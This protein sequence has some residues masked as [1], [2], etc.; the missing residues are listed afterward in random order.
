MATAFTHCLF[1][2][3]VKEGV[4]LSGTPVV[5]SPEAAL[6]CGDQW[7]AV[8]ACHSLFAE[9]AGQIPGF[10]QCFPLQPGCMHGIDRKLESILGNFRNRSRCLFGEIPPC[11]AVVALN[12]FIFIPMGN[13]DANKSGWQRCRVGSAYGIRCGASRVLPHTGEFGVR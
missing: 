2:L 6:L 3:L 9:Q 1:N 8:A 4:E 10:A 7:T 12:A 5:Q 11:T 13:E